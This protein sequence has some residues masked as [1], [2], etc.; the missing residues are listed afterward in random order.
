MWQAKAA[1]KPTQT[2]S[3]MQARGGI[4]ICPQSM[5]HAD[6]LFA[7]LSDPRIYRFLDEEPPTSVQFIK[8]RISR[9]LVGGPPDRSALWLNWTVFQN[10]GIVGYTQATI[11]TAT[12]NKI[13]A[14]IAY[15]MSPMV[16]GKDVAQVAVE[17]TINTLKTQHKVTELVADTDQENRASQRL[18]LRLGFAETHR[19]GCDIFYKCNA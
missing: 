18:L 12:D 10:D 8:D 11:R 17:Q 9:Q 5:A 2:N 14:S 15:V 13:T 6:G 7:A 16:W 3:Y 19:D 1:R 4:I